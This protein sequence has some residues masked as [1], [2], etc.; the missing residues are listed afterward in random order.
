M[1]HPSATPFEITVE[2]DWLPTMEELTI[3][4]S[5]YVNWDNPQSGLKVDIGLSS[6]V[7]VLSAE[8]PPSPISH[9]GPEY[10]DLKLV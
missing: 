1:S 4:T 9:S 5:H 2:L 10:Y 3:S 7:I 8:G 6:Q